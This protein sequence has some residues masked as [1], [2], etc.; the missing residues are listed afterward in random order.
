M[1]LWQSADRVFP[2][3]RRDRV[4]QDI[5]RELDLHVQLE[6]RQNLELGMSQE[7]ATG[8]EGRARERRANP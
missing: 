6:T 7:D 2:Y 3:R 4:E 1:G 5:Q 8:N